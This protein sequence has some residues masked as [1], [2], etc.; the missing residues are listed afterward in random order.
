MKPYE[1]LGKTIWRVDKGFGFGG[2]HIVSQLGLQVGLDWW[3]GRVEFG[4][5]P[6]RNLKNQK[7]QFQIQTSNQQSG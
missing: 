1:L 6:N 3:F 7:V 5:F 2:G 4:R